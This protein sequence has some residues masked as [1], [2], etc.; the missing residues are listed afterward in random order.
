MTDSVTRRIG[1]GFLAWAVVFQGAASAMTLDFR[2]AVGIALRQNPELLAVQAQIAQAKAGVAQAEGARLPKITAT[3]GAT[4]TNDPLNVFGIKLSQRGA[5]FNDF[6]AGQFNPAV[7]GVLNIAPDNLNEPSAV[8]N[9][10]TRLEA[11]LPLYTGGKLQGYM[12]Q[13]RSMLLAAQ[14]GDQAARQQIIA[15]ALQAYDGVYTAQAFE[16]VAAKALEAAQSQVKMVD[17]LY[18]QGVV[19]KSDLLSAQVHLEDVKLQQQQAA[20]M[21]AQAMDALHVVLGVPLTEAIELGPEVRVGMPTGQPDGW[22]GQA[23]ENN[24]QILALRHQ[25]QAASGKVEVAR[26]DL[27]PQV[28]ALARFDTN[29]PTLGFGAHSYTIGAQLTWTLFDGGVA[30]QG[31][32]QAMAA[33][34]ELH[35][36]LQSAENQL[37]MQIQDAYRKAL[38]AQNQLRTRELAVQQAEE[39]ARIVTKRY[40]DG[41]GTLVEMQGAQAQLD[42][43]RADLVL[44]RNQINMQRAALRLALGQ[45]DLAGLQQDPAQPPAAAA[46]AASPAAQP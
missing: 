36:K 13:A 31:V 14:S 2:Q 40:A 43:A 12:Q 25:I 22:I 21:R 7:P 4:R 18:K 24:P 19:I 38:A 42:K 41:V 9:F 17:S 34:M 45:L 33:R 16:G 32:D 46:S 8:N 26:S 1:I 39:A 11:Q 6:G 5:T 35:A 3:V 15:Q 28:G 23:L 29:D 30:R 27:Y 37:G 20:D 44:A 10:S